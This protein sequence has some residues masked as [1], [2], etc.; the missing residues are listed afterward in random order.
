MATRVKKR[1]YLAYCVAQRRVV[2][3]LAA[4]RNS[5]RTAAFVTE[6]GFKIILVAVR[7]LTRLV[8]NGNRDKL[9]A[10]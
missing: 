6:A 10:S 2:V 5:L 4:Q 1:V 8:G 3:V 9:Y 7:R